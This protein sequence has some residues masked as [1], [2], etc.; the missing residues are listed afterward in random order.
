MGVDDP[1]ML[2]LR[3][4]RLSIKEGKGVVEGFAQ[5]YV[6]L[7]EDPP[8]D[9]ALEHFLHKPLELDRRDVLGHFDDPECQR[10][11]DRLAE[12][13]RASEGLVHQTHMCTSSSVKHVS[14]GIGLT[15]RAAAL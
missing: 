15:A 1:D 7:C 8:A 4:G 11:D 6:L 13:G 5:S 2:W 9:A 14:I 3:S 12:T 10:W